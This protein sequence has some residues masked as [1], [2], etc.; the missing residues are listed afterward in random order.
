MSYHPSAPSSD[1]RHG[2]W[3]HPSVSRMS[4]QGYPASA[5]GHSL[6]NTGNA[7]EP[8]SRIPGLDMAAPT[9]SG[10][11]LP[12]MPMM[13][14]GTNSQYPQP[15]STPNPASHV[16][17]LSMPFPAPSPAGQ[18]H[19]PANR[20]PANPMGLN[21]FEIQPTT[22]PLDREE[23]EI[24]D[25][26][27]GKPIANNVTQSTSS[28]IAKMPPVGEDREV[29]STSS[30][31][32]SGSRIT[33]VFFWLINLILTILAYNPPMSVSGDEYEPSN[34]VDSEMRNQPAAPG[35][36]AD[37]TARIVPCTAKSPAQLRVQAQG[38]LLGLAPHNI[39]YNELAAEG[40]NPIVLRQLY[41][42]VGIKVASPKVLNAA[43][44]SFQPSKE[45]RPSQLTST[46][47]APDSTESRAAPRISP[48]QENEAQKPHANGATTAPP[49]HAETTKPLERKELIA[50]ML[51]SKAAQ[52][53]DRKE[54]SPITTT[55]HE[56]EPPSVPVAEAPSQEKDTRVKE[57]NK[58]QTELARKRMEQLKKQGLMK[59]QAK[60]QP[61]PV[62]ENQSPPTRAALLPTRA[63]TH[64]PLPDRPPVALDYGSHLPGLSM[65]PTRQDPFGQRLAGQDQSTFP[66]LPRAT[67]RKR[68]RASDFDDLNT[69]PNKS[70]DQGDSHHPEER[71]VI[72]ISDDEFYG[73]DENDVEMADVPAEHPLY[74]APFSP[75]SRMASRKPLSTEP[76]RSRL[77]SNSQSGTPQSHRT[78][79]DENLRKKD[80]AIQEMHRK[81]AELE[82]RKR[83]KTTA[84]PQA[85][86]AV[87][88]R[89]LGDS[90]FEPA[91]GISSAAPT[92][93][94]G[95]LN[96]SDEPS[97][98]ELS[99]PNREA[100]SGTPTAQML[101]SMNES[102]LENVR[103]RLLRKKEIE[104]GLP[105]LEADLL[106]SEARLNDFKKEQEK[107][108][109]DIAKGKKG[110]QEL[111][112]E[113]R[114]LGLEINGLSFEDIEAAQ[115][116]SQSREQ[117]Q[118]A[119]TGTLA[120]SYLPHRGITYFN[121]FSPG[122]RI[123]CDKEGRSYSGCP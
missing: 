73:D 51:A 10:P 116:R 57:K 92:D 6:D 34:L 80:L 89:S 59:A 103:L 15:M 29:F 81:I 68:P 31:R 33:P 79:D 91:V 102:Q 86:R 109:A 7:N 111:A 24:T 16:N 12:V 96:S 67:Q 72:D 26:E 55:I 2:Q 18:N 113:L 13:N 3:A 122:S 48:S 100:L 22:S 120:F 77:M 98:N 41:E 45:S 78:T 50:R 1:Q 66:T 56:K 114:S 94:S 90:P 42:E 84:S 105:S 74:G 93:V 25:R 5:F 70:L 36:K 53:G 35:S 39:R 104:S 23:G 21:G 37:T 63:P 30:S 8:N 88:P 123:D 44:V 4:S 95:N 83:L 38:A 28:T 99:I 87:S 9:A 64:H 117:P 101:A 46:V 19:V 43:A 106:K 69:M 20:A 58:A 71:L 54:P 85:A 118:A 17:S 27:D 61:T 60:A 47:P 49:S 76:Y 115:R 14:Q 11:G 65:A 112:D 97:S 119:E 108:I 32:D 52:G 82:Q 75:D 40:I 107:L 121:H 62:S 110:R